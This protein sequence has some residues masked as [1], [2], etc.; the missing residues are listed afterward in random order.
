MARERAAAYHSE[1]FANSMDRYTR[2]NWARNTGPKFTKNR[3]WQHSGWRCKLPVGFKKKKKGNRKRWFG[4]PPRYDTKRRTLFAEP[5]PAN[6]PEPGKEY[7][8]IYNWIPTAIANSKE[9]PK[10]RRVLLGSEG[11]RLLKKNYY[12][13]KPILMTPHKNG[14]NNSQPAGDNHSSYESCYPEYDNEIS[15][16][17]YLK[18]PLPEDE[19]FSSIS[20]SSLSLI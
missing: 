6:L 17:S 8:V 16:D 19:G 7:D 2:I 3:G 4:A 10:S 11:A 9:N 15:L 13:L 5:V 18:V 1:Q 12:P 20:N 14:H